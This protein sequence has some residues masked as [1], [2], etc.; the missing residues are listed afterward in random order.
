MKVLKLTLGTSLFYVFYLIFT[1]WLARVVWGLW[2][3]AFTSNGYQSHI[4]IDVNGSG[5]A[6]IEFI[7]MII[8][9]I[10]TIALPFIVYSKISGIDDEHFTTSY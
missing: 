7:V 4:I 10:A 3:S 9:I 8:H 5:E 6:N 2:W 1:I